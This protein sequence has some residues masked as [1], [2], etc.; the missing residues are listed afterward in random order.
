VLA[1]DLTVRV[2]AK[3]TGKPLEG[4]SVCLG[5]NADPVQLGA[6]RTSA[7]GKAAFRDV[8]GAPLSL[9]VS[10]S[11]YQS[12]R[13]G[14]S[15]GPFDQDITMLLATG[16]SAGFSC[17][18]GA[19]VSARP[20]PAPGFR[21][22]RGAPVTTDRRVTLDF[23]SDGA[24]QYRASESSDFAGAE[25]QPIEGTPT[26]EL[27]AGPGRKTVYLQLRRYR[28]TEGA[29]LE[30]RSDALSDSIVLR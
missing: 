3:S 11:G 30:T 6:R 28:E 1:G 4:A 10:R 22:D 14:V 23:A 12:E 26:F 18:A 13:R 21:L 2:L 7:D 15:A 17:E 8:P 24:T 5:T 27:S 29:R 9:I 25:W 16:R 20:A 19:V